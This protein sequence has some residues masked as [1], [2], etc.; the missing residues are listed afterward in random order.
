MTTDQK[1]TFRQTKIVAT[2]G[3]ASC[4]EGVL[5]GMFEA[6]LDV[7]RINASHGA[8]EEDEAT[9]QRVR[10]IARTVGRPI[11]ILYDLQGPKIRLSDFEGDPIAVAQGDEIRIAVGRPSE[12]GEI[13]SD[14][15]FLDQDLSVGDPILIDDGIIALKATA[16]SKGL[17]VARAENAGLILPR[18]GIN[19]PGSSISAPAVSEKDLDDA[20]FAASLHVDFIA[21]SFV[22]KAEDVLQLQDLLA[23]KGASTPIISKIEKPR[24]LEDISRILQHS[25]GVMVARGDLGVEIPPERVPVIQKQIIAAGMKLGRPVITAT[26]MLDSMTRNPRPTRAEASDVANAVLDGT[27]AVMLSGETAIGDYPVESV[28]MMSDVIRYTEQNAVR[29]TFRRRREHLL[30]TTPEAVTEAACQVA[31]NVGAHALCAF[32]Q[33]GSTALLAARL[34]PEHPILAFTTNETVRD[35]LTL[36]WGVRP[37]QIRPAHM[38]DEMIAELDKTLQTDEVASV[39]DLIVLLMGAPTHKMGRTNLMLVYRVGS[40]SGLEGPSHF[41]DEDE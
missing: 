9:I 26:Q 37:Y 11:G 31:D 34:R 2:L 23:T 15:E 36:V 1:T 27:D 13:G 18:K 39:G 22:R 8:H 30:E 35:R 40:W 7:V 4:S 17:V 16:V 38:T 14:Y 25:W 41:D 3:P 33:S 32:T 10:D 12:K 6:G 24:A 5:R 28:Q 20:F 21:L 19:L 29:P